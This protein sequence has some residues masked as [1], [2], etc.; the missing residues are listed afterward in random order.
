MPVVHRDSPLCLLRLSLRRVKF[1]TLENLIKEKDISK[2][3]LNV[4]NIGVGER[5]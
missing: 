1:D 4:E 5:V 3:A 2:D